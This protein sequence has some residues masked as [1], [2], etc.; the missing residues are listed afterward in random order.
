[1]Y[2]GP[3]LMAWLLG[4]CSSN[5]DASGAG[6]AGA[7]DGGSAGSQAQG[8]GGGSFGVGGGSGGGAP[9]NGCKRVDLVIAVDNSSSMSEEKNA[10]ANDVF[11]AFASALLRIGGG[12]ED[13]RIGV[14]DA[15]PNP[16]NYHTRGVSGECN[17][18]SGKVW[19]ESSSPNLTAEFKCV[20]DIYSGDMKCSG[21]NDDEQPASAAAA[22]LESP[23]STGPNAGFSRDD[24]LLVV[25]AITDEDESPVPTMDAPAVYNRL[26]KAKGGDVKKM[27]FLGIGGARTCA[28]VYGNADD[29]V[30][31]RAVSNLF[32]A[33]GR[34][35]FWDLCVGRLEDGLTEAMAVIETACTEFEPPR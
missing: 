29:A 1:M 22:S 18:S 3:V 23:W 27:V 25:V 11:P 5:G 17:F 7:G 6:G 12:L 8:S 19:M 4:A 26:V 28:G 24:A 14:L 16:A 21:D 10:I 2:L 32:I 31:L 35:V 30:T 9:R 20:G 33:Q 13:Y 34:G 15:C